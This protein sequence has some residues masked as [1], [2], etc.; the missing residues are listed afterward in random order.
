MDKIDMLWLGYVLLVIAMIV[1]YS[2]TKGDD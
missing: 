2:A 1:F